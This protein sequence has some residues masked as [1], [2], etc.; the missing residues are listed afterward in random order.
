MSK[1]KVGILSLF[2]NYNYGAVLQAYSLQRTI[3]EMGYEASHIKYHREINGISTKNPTL[4]QKIKSKTSVVFKL[5]RSGQI[6]SFL[7]FKITKKEEKYMKY[8]HERHKVFDAFINENMMTS[9]LEYD[10]HRDISKCVFDYDIFVCGSDN[11]WNKVM[12]DSSFML[13]FVPNDKLKVAYAPGMSTYTLNKKLE[14]IVTDCAGRID[15]ISCREEIGATLLSKL[16]GREVKTVLDPT[17]LLTA[18]EW[19]KIERKPNIQKLPDEY[20]FCY[21]LGEA[22]HIRKQAEMLK[23]LTNLPI[24]TLPHPHGY[25]EEDE[26][27]FGDYQIN[28]VGPAEFVYLVNH[29]RY[30]FTTSFHAVVFS[31][32]FQ[33]KFICTRRFMNKAEETNNLRVDNILK[34]M[35][36]TE[37]RIITHESTEKDIEGLLELPITWNGQD[38]DKLRQPSL[39][40]LE[41]ALKD[42]ECKL[43]KKD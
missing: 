7:K 13:D 21:L 6:I 10:G 41:N 14:K 5:F 39:S 8:I 27:G 20:L 4:L 2:F 1:R 36:I 30:V 31:I 16:T 12:F 26:K 25:N 23:K 42:S 37:N 9:G 38:L 40:Y 11:I 15:Y 19:S 32:I 3:R 43:T 22:P 34:L 18:T 28:E 35:N 24:V 29:S 17:L 33:K